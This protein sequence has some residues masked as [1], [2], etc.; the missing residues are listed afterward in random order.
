MPTQIGRM[1]ATPI[2]VDG[3]KI[4][5]LII[6]T[7]GGQNYAVLFDSKKGTRAALNNKYCLNIASQ[8][9]G[10]ATRRGS[11]SAH[12]HISN[13]YQVSGRWVIHM[14]QFRCVT[15]VAEVAISKRILIR[16]DHLVPAYKTYHPAGDQHGHQHQHFARRQQERARTSIRASTPT[17]TYRLYAN[18]YAYEALCFCS[19]QRFESLPF[20]W[21]S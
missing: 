10:L 9:R 6:Y 15:V 12:Q 3:N 18:S 4:Q 5:N 7:A 1:T 14:L 17:S 13:G 19:P 11:S 20:H 16:E 21:F 2:W 8:G